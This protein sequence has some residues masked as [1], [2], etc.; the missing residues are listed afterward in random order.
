MS[1]ARRRFVLCF[2][3]LLAALSFAPA[4]ATEPNGLTALAEARHHAAVKQYD[5]T[6]SYYQQARIDS[7]QVYVWS[8]LVLDS[9]REITDKP[10]DRVAALEEHLSRMKKLE[11]L[12]KKV[13]RLGFT[14]SYDV[15]AA[16][17]YCLEAEHWLARE[18]NTK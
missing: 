16:E 5:V 18:K 9:H 15:G 17:Y 1:L 12:I 3:L 10:T 6:W 4:P 7:Y 8:R 2:G 13:R 11:A 14:N